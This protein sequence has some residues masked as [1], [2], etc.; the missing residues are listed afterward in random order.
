MLWLSARGPFWAL[1]PTLTACSAE[2]ELGGIVT[3]FFTGRREVTM[4]CAEAMADHQKTTLDSA[5]NPNC[6]PC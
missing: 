1:P 5:P 2:A 4:V 3:E 6:L